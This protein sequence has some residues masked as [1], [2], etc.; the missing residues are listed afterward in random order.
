MKTKVNSFLF[1]SLLLIVF[2]L[3][4]PLG[5]NRP[6]AW[7]LFQIAIFALTIILCIN[8][9]SQQIYS[10]KKYT[11]IIALWIAMIV[12]A[13]MQIVHLPE[14]VVEWLSPVAYELQRNVGLLEFSLS[15]DPGQ[16]A[17]SLQKLLSFFC[18]F[19]S[20]LLLLNSEQRIK[21]LLMTMLAAGTFQATYG[22][23][24]VL[25]KLEHSWIFNIETEQIATGSFVY[26]NHYANFLMLCLAAGIGLLVT[27]LQKDQMRSP[28]DLL[29]SVAST[30]LSSKALFRV[31]LAI[32]VIG[33]VMSR[34]RMG[35]TAFFVAMT[36]TGVLALFLIKKRSRGLTL[37]IISMFIV[38]LLIVSAYF[39]L[40]KVKSRLGETSLAQES[41]DEVIVDALPMIKDFPISGSGAGSF[42][43]VFPG[44][45]NADVLP[46]YDHTHNDYLQFAI[47]YGLLGFSILLLICLY[48]AYKSLHAM[49]NRKNSIFKGSAFACV[50]VFIGMAMHTSVDFPLQAYANACYFV[51]FIALAVISSSLKLRPR[52]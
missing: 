23:L 13:C 7:N 16:S 46:F 43:S 18:L 28:R 21:A 3:P 15:L 22:S 31:C 48:A 14:G 26:K 34:S 2:L 5:A 24:E 50:M 51:L 4:I 17:I 30:L 49:R 45:Q 25:L 47:E 33:L 12:L 52:S 8:S 9:T 37:L 42:Y 1:S 27:S 10:L 20:A 40:D 39:G 35:N 32:M 19:L 36:V 29:R 44:Y 6:W 38:D 41:R 11:V